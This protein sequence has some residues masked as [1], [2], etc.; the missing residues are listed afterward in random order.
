VGRLLRQKIIFCMRIRARWV[1][2]DGEE[3]I[4]RLV[5]GLDKTEKRSAPEFCGK[6]LWARVM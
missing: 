1:E 5:K 3:E 6:V 2:C 4:S